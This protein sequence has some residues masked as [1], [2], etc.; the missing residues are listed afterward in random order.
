MHDRIREIACAISLHATA[1]NR[2]IERKT[3]NILLVEDEP[4]ILRELTHY[5]QS[6]G[7]PYHILGT[8]LDGQHA[9]EIIDE[10]GEEIDFLLTDIQI[11]IMTGL[12]LIAY[13]RQKHPRILCSILTGFNEFTYAQQALRM[14]VMDYISKPIDEEELRRLLQKAYEQTCLQ[15]I[16][17]TAVQSPDV[18]G[19]ASSDQGHDAD[20]SAQYRILLLNFGQFAYRTEYPCP[21]L[22]EK[23]SLRHLETLLNVHA[24]LY[25]KW[26][27]IRDAN[28]HSCFVLFSFSDDQLLRVNRLWQI[29]YQDLCRDFSMI[30]MVTSSRSVDL[31]TINDSIRQLSQCVSHHILFAS[32]SMLRLEE[33]NDPLPLSRERHE[34]LLHVIRRMAALLVQC[35]MDLL[36][37]ESE[38]FFDLLR[39]APITQEALYQLFHTLFSECAVAS[40]QYSALRDALYNDIIDDLLLLSGSWEELQ[41]SLLSIFEDLCATIANESSIKN[42]KTGLLMQVDHYIQEHYMDNINTQSIAKDFGFTPAYLSKLFRDYRKVTPSEYI[43]SLRIDRARDLLTAPDAPSVKEV[44]AAVGYE[45]PLYFSKVFKKETGLSPKNYAGK[46]NIS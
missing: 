8:A 15:S 21:Q 18:P 46:G 2:G 33:T 1:V 16:S 10:R 17:R 35:R 32:S 45:D 3:M 26:W 22:Q 5:I 40:F 28:N 11:P 25:Q 43:T 29:L 41:E 23:D 34:A 39:S 37:R 38:T 27:M 7:E 13:V 42:S 44:A 30:T 24:S 36:R 14:Q 12:E 31:A 4:P 20:L 6:F 19:S 9:R